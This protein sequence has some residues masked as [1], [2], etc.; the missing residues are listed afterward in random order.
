[1]IAISKQA[2]KPLPCLRFMLP[3]SRNAPW[4]GGDGPR[5]LSLVAKELE[6]AD[7]A[8]LRA[9]G[10]WQR[11]LQHDGSACPFGADLRR[12]LFL[13]HPP[14]AAEGEAAAVDARRD[15]ARRSR[16]DRR[17]LHRDGRE[18]RQQ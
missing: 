8:G 6:H 4:F 3:S 11:C 16:G 12:F 13:P 10:W 2:A 1:M 7:Y 14:A 5:P 18:S 15:P 17:R 9:G